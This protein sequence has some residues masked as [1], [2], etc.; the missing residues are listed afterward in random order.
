MKTCDDCGTGGHTS[1]ACYSRMSGN[2]I[3]W[4]NITYPK[5]GNKSH[6]WKEQ[7]RMECLE[8]Q[9]EIKAL[10]ISL[11]LQAL[12]PS[13]PTRYNHPKARVTCQAMSRM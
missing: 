1:N 3:M 5:P 6:T 13:S 12:I 10:K 9:Y 8:N 7:L 11:G 2:K 4:G